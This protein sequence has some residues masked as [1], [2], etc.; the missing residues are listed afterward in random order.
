MQTKRNDLQPNFDVKKRYKLLTLFPCYEFR[1]G[2][3]IKSL[4]PIGFIHQVMWK[5]ILTRHAAKSA[6]YDRDGPL[7]LN[8]ALSSVS[9]GTFSAGT[10]A[11]RPA[12]YSGPSRLFSVYGRIAG[13]PIRR[14]SGEDRFIPVVFAGQTRENTFSHAR[15]RRLK[16]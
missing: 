2:A 15:R 11:D 1:E 13:K 12:F 9:Y 16:I 4:R 5:L 7:W 8:F 10:A 3:Q 6:W 14:G